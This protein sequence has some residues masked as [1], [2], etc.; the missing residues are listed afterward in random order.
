MM[1]TLKVY[2]VSD[3][4]STKGPDEQDLILTKK[5]EESLKPF[6]VFE[7][8]S[9][10]RHRMDVLN[11]ICSLF[12]EWIKKVTISKVRRIILIHLKPL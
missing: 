2:G 10:L 6:N 5:L 1:P 8:A 3:P 4:V 9:D 11:K 7:S 12:K